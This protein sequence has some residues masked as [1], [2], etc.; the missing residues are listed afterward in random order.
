[1]E[2]LQ[3]AYA[4]AMAE[5]EAIINEIIGEETANQAVEKI[6]GI[7]HALTSLPEIRSAF[8]VRV[9]ECGLV[10]DKAKGCYVFAGKSEQPV[11][12]ETPADMQEGK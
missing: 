2:A 12:P 7:K 1:M 3:K 10:F 5:G 8:S 4:T 6:R 11:Q 9:A